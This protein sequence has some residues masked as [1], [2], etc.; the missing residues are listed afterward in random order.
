LKKDEMLNPLCAKSRI[1]VL[2][3]NEDSIWTKS[4]KY[5]PVLRP[6]TMRLR[7]SM[8]VEQWRTLKQGNCKN[9][10]CQGILPDDKITIVKS[11]IGDPD[12]KKDEY[13]LLKRTLYGLR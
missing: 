7:V 4:K 2:G 11:P 13:W 8:A 5:A 3:N 9:A 10:F 6:N 1:V 12:A